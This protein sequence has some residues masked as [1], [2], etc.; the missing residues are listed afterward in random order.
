MRIIDFTKLK[1]DAGSAVEKN[2][3]TINADLCIFG[4][5]SAGIAAAIQARRMGMDVVIVESSRHLGGLTTGGLG[6]TDI[7]NKA[8][9]GGIA[10]E[11][12][13]E[14]GK[15]YGSTEPDGTKW[16][17]E[18]GVAKQIYL[19]WLQSA[20]VPVYFNQR[21]E[22]VDRQNG[23]ISRLIMT[24]GNR[25]SAA[26]FID[27]TYEGDLLASAAVAYHV[28]REANSVYRET[29][30]G[31]HY[32]HPN[33]N[34]K[35]WV[36]P[37]TIPGKPDSGLIPGVTD[38]PVLRQG[39]GDASVQAYN[40]RMCLTNVPDNR[41]PFPQPNGYDPDTYTLLSRYI[42]AGVWDA[43]CLHRMMPNGKTDLNN[44]GAISTDHIGGG[45]KW[46]E[47]D[48]HTRERL[49]QDHLRYNLGMLYFL[50]HD[51]RVPESIRR[52]V[53]Q[54]GL[55]ADEYPDSGHF[56]PQLYVR[57]A[58]RMISEVVM[59][60]RHCRGY[61]VVDDPVGLAAYSMDSHNC[62][63]LV[64]DGRCINEGNVEVAPGAPYPISYRAIVPKGEQCVNLLVPV[65][66]SSSHIAFGSI[67]MEPVFMIL[68]QSAA[69]AAA[70]ALEASCAVQEVD[71]SK[72]RNK[73]LAD[74]QVLEWK[75]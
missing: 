67:R 24:N 33:H 64:I 26:V 47:G 42:Q 68:G 22:K 30:N 69:T 52:E 4:G 40:F 9:I 72:L 7:G 34:F 73:L 60:E 35:V 53:G 44:F 65:C 51:E 59:T 41:I 74:K 57:E 48:S 16:T 38:A 29:L 20:E 56:T 21:L 55:P 23:K 43:L 50:S 32:G 63:R 12:Y 10:R 11:F 75:K 15:H 14:V 45:D 18:P 27:A 19:N 70:L 28:G 54:W 8:A 13:G 36:D 49:F 46:P 1:Y 6:A 71:Y 62:R 25:F 31:V 2:P 37:Y 17:F 5:S 58:R 39:Q 3:L 61:D 66:L